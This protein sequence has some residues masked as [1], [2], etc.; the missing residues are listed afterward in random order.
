MTKFIDTPA[1][2]LL[3]KEFFEDYEKENWEEKAS[4]YFVDPHFLDWQASWADS[5][6]DYDLDD[7]HELYNEYIKWEPSSKEN[8]SSN[9]IN[10]CESRLTEEKGPAACDYN[11][12]NY[13]QYNSHYEDDMPDSMKNCIELKGPGLGKYYTYADEYLLSLK[14]LV[15]EEL[16]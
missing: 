10:Y 2:R 13:L 5:F 4:R 14:A 6:S 8:F 7:I 15:A 3:L 1:G 12:I 16:Q 9:V 11:Y